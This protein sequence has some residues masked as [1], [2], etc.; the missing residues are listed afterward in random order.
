MTQTYSVAITDGGFGPVDIKI[1][2]NFKDALKEA[3]SPLEPRDIKRICNLYAVST[4]NHKEALAQ[5]Q[6]IIEGHLERDSEYYYHNDSQDNTFIDINMHPEDDPY[7]NIR[8]EIGGYA[9]FAFAKQEDHN[10]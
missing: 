6:E 4:D 10:K 8:I 9:F 1:N 5:I 3:L 7:N 2:L